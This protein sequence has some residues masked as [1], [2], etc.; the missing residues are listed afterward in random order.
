MKNKK[1]LMNNIINYKNKY[2]LIIKLMNIIKVL[3]VI[4]K[5]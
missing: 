4:Y 2:K 1:L 5:N 3:K